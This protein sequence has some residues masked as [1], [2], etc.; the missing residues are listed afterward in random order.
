[1]KIILFVCTG[2]SCRSPMARGIA[3]SRLPGRWQ[4]KVAFSSAGTSAYDGMRAA[5]NAVLVLGEIGI[6]ISRHRARLLTGEMAESSS[7]VVAM[8]RRHRE[9]IL[10]IA[11]GSEGKVI[12]LGDLDLKRGSPDVQDPIGGDAA[13]YRRTRDEIAQL[14]FLLIDY[15]AERFKFDE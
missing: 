7:L 14:I 2:N 9:E 12:V 5:E 10:R 11:P 13:V 4:G 6:D 1:M 8:T 15:I 3:A